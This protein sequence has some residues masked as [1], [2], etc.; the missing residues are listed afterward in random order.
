MS[1]EAMEVWGAL[2]F[3]FWLEICPGLHSRF[4]TPFVSVMGAGQV[5]MKVTVTSAR[6]TGRPW[7]RPNA[8]AGGRH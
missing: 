5:K 4:S 7:R 1:G 6:K 3:P 8:R 2:G